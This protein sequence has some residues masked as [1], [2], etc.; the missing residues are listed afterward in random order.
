MSSSWPSGRITAVCLSAAVAVAAT[1][2]LG[3]HEQAFVVT[4]R[5]MLPGLAPGDVVAVGGLFEGLRSPRRHER[6]LVRMP[7]GTDVVK[8]VAGLPGERLEIQDGCLVIDGQPV[9][10]APTLLAETAS[11]VT[12]GEWHRSTRDGLVWEEY[13]HLVIDPSRRPGDPGYRV[14]G[15]IYDDLPQDTEEHRRLEPV[16][17][18]GLAVVVHCAAA[19]APG[20]QASPPRAELPATDAWWPSARVLVRVGPQS[21]AVRLPGE[22]LFAVV[23]GRLEGRFVVGAWPM[24]VQEA[25]GSDPGRMQRMPF[26]QP[27][28]QDW[29]FTSPARPLVTV[30]RAPTLAVGLPD[31]FDAGRQHL[32]VTIE[33]RRPWRA[34]RLLPAADG[35]TAWTIPAG[36]FF[37]L[38][39][40]PSASRDSRHFGP[41]AADRLVGRMRGVS[42]T[43]RP[44]LR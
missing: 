35:T 27:C 37:L 15:P 5:S 4:G 16:F 6:W 29:T 3:T 42:Q 13:R 34:V 40:H 30:E 14:P 1:A 7:D 2:W 24:T 41:I 11:D 28:P 19:A 22:G 36:C 38:G 44:P 17:D 10:P 12:G 26:P 21:A 23:A 25:A 33:D 32:R 43:P 39:D 8:R 9:V 20:R 31:D 18:V